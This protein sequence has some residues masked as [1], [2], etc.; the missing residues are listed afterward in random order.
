LARAENLKN[1]GAHKIVLET[2][3][4][5]IIERRW[6][7]R[8]YKKDDDTT[9]TSQYVFHVGGC[10]NGDFRKAWTSAWSAASLA[11][12]KLD[13]NGSPETV[14]L[15]GK[16]ETVMLPS[17]FF[18]DLRRSGIRNMVRAGVREGVA[19]AIS[20]HRTRAVFDRLQRRFR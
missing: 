15:N 16:E 6:A 7:A 18:H 8:E 10:P 4:T 3:L 14:T 13:Q 9:A 17:R 19:M 2:Q 12:P 11:K 20:G 5:E 1:S